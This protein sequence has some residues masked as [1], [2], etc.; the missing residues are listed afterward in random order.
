MKSA[1]RNSLYRPTASAREA[2][3][4]GIPSTTRFSFG[5]TT[6]SFWAAAPTDIKRTATTRESFF[7]DDLQHNSD[8]LRPIRLATSGGPS[9]LCEVIRV[10]PSP[11]VAPTDRA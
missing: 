2:G 9:F 6:L 11:A 4:F 8:G 10:R 7:M 1:E 5:A 3:I